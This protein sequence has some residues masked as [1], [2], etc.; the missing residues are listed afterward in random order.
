MCVE[1]V[2]HPLRLSHQPVSSG[3]LDGVTVPLP[4]EHLP[5][6]NPAE[7]PN[8]FVCG[9]ENPHGLHLRV[10]RDGSDAVARYAPAEHQQGY[11]GRFHGGLVG[12]LV[13][14]MLVYAGAPHGLWGMTAKVQYRLRHAISFDDELTLRGGLTQRSAR[15]F[16]AAVTIH[17]ADGLLVAEGDGTCV[18]VE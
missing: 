3:K 11:P 15:G 4:L 12:L 16:R 1:E 17:R 14:E 9:V 18:F 6:L 8:C 10:H 2:G 13:D 7:F 5:L